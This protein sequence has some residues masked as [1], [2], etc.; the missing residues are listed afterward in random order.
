VSDV[1]ALRALLA[2]ASAIYLPD[3]ERATAGIHALRVLRELDQAQ[4]AGRLRAHPNGAAAMAAMA[5]AAEPASVGITQVSEILCTPGLR[6]LGVL[7]PPFGLATLY[8]A[9]VVRAAAYPAAAANLASLLTTTATS[10]WRQQ[11][12]FQPQG[13]PK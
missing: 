3:P 11:G 13:I 7:P 8:S 9:A 5:L 10:P 4:P 6:L 1:P 12:G 2:R